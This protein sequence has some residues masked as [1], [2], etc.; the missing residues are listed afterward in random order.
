MAV[1]SPTRNYDET[2]AEIEESLGIVPEWFERL[3]EEDFVNEWPTFKRYVLGEST[4][5]GKYRELIGLAVAA[6]T[7]CQYCEHFHTEAAKMH[8]A[9]EE[10]LSELSYLASITARYSA[11]LHAMEY[12]LDTFKS[13]TA[14]IGTHLQAQAADDD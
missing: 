11:M 14:A 2:R 1:T 12:D 6:N 5:P 10:E 7:K 9:T 13:E 4:I 8:G 3:P